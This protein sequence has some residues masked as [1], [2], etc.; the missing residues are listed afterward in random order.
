MNATSE[1]SILTDRPVST[2]V[3]NFQTKASLPPASEALV[4]FR[5]TECYM[6]R[7]AHDCSQVYVNEATEPDTS[8]VMPSGSSE[9]ERTLADEYQMKNA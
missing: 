7:K 1:P 5:D 6:I 2:P 4:A 9:V 8:H 3:P